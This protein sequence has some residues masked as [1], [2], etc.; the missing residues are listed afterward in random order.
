MK[1]WNWEQLRQ[2][3]AP[4]AVQRLEELKLRV[5]KE[6]SI[7]RYEVRCLHLFPLSSMVFH[8]CSMFFMVFDGFSKDFHGFS[9]VSH[10]FSMF[11]Y[12]VL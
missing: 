6:M 12:D 4:A 10:G 3:L 2:Q 8:G 9:M 5:Q 11:F 1:G 7:E